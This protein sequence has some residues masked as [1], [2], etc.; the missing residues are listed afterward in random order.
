MR[1]GATNSMNP[2][3]IPAS[4]LDDWRKLLADPDKHW[5]ENYSAMSIAKAWHEADGF[6][7]SIAAVFRASDEPFASFRP[8]LIIPEHKV[9]LPGGGRDSQNDVW[10]LARHNNGLA[11]ITVEGKVAEPFGDTIAEWKENASP[12]KRERLAFLTKTIG[13]SGEMPGTVRY[14][15][16]HRATAALIEAERFCANVALMLVHSFSLEDVGFADF[17]AFTTLFSMT[18]APDQIVRL[19]EPNAIPLYVAWIRHRAAGLRV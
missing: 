15:L 8:L 5:R 11:S 2:V 3:Y 4:E 1:H 13:L 14:Q 6:P 10:V 17:R 16:L 19:G 9:K 18:P 12:G 7:A